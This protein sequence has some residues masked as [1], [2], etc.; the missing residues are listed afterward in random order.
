MSLLEIVRSARGALGVMAVLARGAVLAPLQALTVSPAPLDMP[1]ATSC[2]CAP[3]KGALRRQRDIS[4]L[5]VVRAASKPRSV[6][7]GGSVRV[8][9]CAVCLA[10]MR[11]GEKA[12]RLL[13]E[14]GHR[15]FHLEYIDRWFRVSSTWPL[16]R[17]RPGEVDARKGGGA[18]P[19]ALVVQS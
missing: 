16:C 17:G 9:E 15:R 5:P 3:D 10:E 4:A 18:A 12:G 19:V 6:A 7:D 8:V 1:P 14:C 2:A 13:P 11:D